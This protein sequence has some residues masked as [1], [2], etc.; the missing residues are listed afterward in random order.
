MVDLELAARRQVTNAMLTRYANGNRQEKSEVLDSWADRTTGRIRRRSA[1]RLTLLSTGIGY[2]SCRPKAS[3]PRPAQPARPSRP[4][5]R[6]RRPPTSAPARSCRTQARPGRSR[7]DPETGSR[8]VDIIGNTCNS[9]TRPSG[10]VA[11]YMGN[12]CS[13]L[14][15]NNAMVT[16]NIST[17]ARA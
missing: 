2:S 12:V 4:H 13:S 10:A 1:S 6:S 11:V 8:D 3:C 5:P 16:N 17:P 9:I 15:L 14:E 7:T